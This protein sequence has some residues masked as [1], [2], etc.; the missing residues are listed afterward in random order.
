M[1]E[2]KIS[3]NM[4]PKLLEVAERAKRPDA[5]FLAL[6]HLIDVPALKRAFNRLRKKAAVGVDGRTVEQYGENLEGNLEDLHERMRTKKYRHQ[7]LRRTHIRKEDG[8]LRPIGISATEDKIVQGALRDVLEAVYEPAFYEGSYGFRP[9]RSAHDA[10]RFL[11]ARAEKGLVNWVLEADIKSFFDSINRQVLQEMLQ[12]RVPDGSIKRLVGKC[13]NVGVLEGEEL[14]WSEE[15][16]TQGS[17]ISPLFGNIYRHYVLDEWFETVVKPRLKGRAYLVRYADDFIMTFETKT[18]AERV[19]RVLPKR[20]GKFGLELHPEK[21]KLIPFYRPYRKSEERKGPGTFDFL[22][23]T[24]YWRRS[25]SNRWR[26]GV[27]TRR[28]SSN[29]FLKRISQWCRSHRH[30]PAKEQHR[31]LRQKLNGYIGYF[32]VNGNQKSL[33]SV[34]Y[35][36]EKIWGKWLRRRSQKGKR[37]SWDTYYGSF[38]KR[39]PLPKSRV[40][41]QIW[42]RE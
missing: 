21:T 36:T 40:R 9:R 26:L 30:L 11:N 12:E 17:I 19:M 31:T 41:V 2:T 7:P 16:T 15:G 10:I 28:K 32:G 27:K 34:V 1:S 35:Q 20:L 39:L 8:S 5:R 24:L 18:D 4:S 22:G 38:L 37:L 3:R 23:F 14:S 25:R 29:S 33:D 42:A 6:A 13:L